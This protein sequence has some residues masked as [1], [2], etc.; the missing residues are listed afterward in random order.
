M[1]R[2]SD[3]EDMAAALATLRPSPRPTFAAELD[4][5]VAAGFP[6][7]AK[8]RRLSISALAARLHGL[9]PQ[10]LAFASGGT[11]LAAIVIATVVVASVDS[12]TGPT[13]IERQVAK[14]P[15]ATGSAEEVLR[16]AGAPPTPPI[17]QQARPSASAAQGASSAVG[18]G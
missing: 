5:R 3:N 6:P 2:F 14:D 8:T 7:P 15:A 18:I 1:E 11:A 9:S 4:K 17:V 13:T 10:R 12:G 16:H